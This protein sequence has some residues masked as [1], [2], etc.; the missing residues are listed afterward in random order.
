MANNLNLNPIVL[1]TFDANVVL[2]TKGVG[3]LTVKRIT[4]HSA[5]SGD[6]FALEDED[7]TPIFVISQDATLVQTLD[8]GD[9][10]GFSN[11]VVFDF[12]DAL[13]SGLSAGDIVLIYLK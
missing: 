4:L 6:R 3:P 13:Q 10:F 1:D 5:A 12:D 9:G 7:G 2:R 11:G 8:F